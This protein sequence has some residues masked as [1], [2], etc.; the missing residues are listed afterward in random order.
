[1]GSALQRRVEIWKKQL[2]DLGKRNRLVNF[3]EG[4]RNNVKITSPSID[5]M[6]N[7]IVGSERSL[8]FP[9]AMKVEI[10]EDGEESYN[11]VIEGDIET[12]RV[13][14]D[15]QKTLRA[16]RLKAKTSIEEQGI[17]ILYLTFGS[18]K[19][20]ESDN[21]DVFMISP[22]VLVPVSLSIESATSPF[23]LS[24][25]E[26]EIVVNPSLIYKFESDFG[27]NIPEFDSSKDG[28]MDYLKEVDSLTSN[29]GWQITTD[30]HLTI[31]SFLKINMYKDLD[32]HDEKLNSNSVVSAIAGE[33]DAISI[34]SEFND[35][36]HDSNTKP[37]DTYQVVDADSSQQ[38]AVLLSK[39]GTS[40][41]LQGP[42][43]TGKSQTITNIISEALADGKKVLF[44][45]EKMA[46][47]QV[48]YNRLSAVGLSD[49]CLALH[50]HKAKKKDILR[51]LANSTNIDRKRVKEEVLTQLDNLDRK[52]SALNVYQQELH[53]P[54]S[55]LNC[56]IFEVNGRLA[57][58]S[59]VPDI[60]FYIND[61]ET[62]YLTEL[63]ERRYILKELSTTIGKRSEDYSSNVWRNATV[64]YL[65][66]ELRHDI[67]SKFTLL[68]PMLES[69]DRCFKESVKKLG[70]DIKPILN[71]IDKLVEL[72]SLAGTSPTIPTKWV[73]EDDIDLLSQK[74]LDY[75]EKCQKII[76]LKNILS[77]L[78]QDELFNLT[79]TDVQSKITTL[80]SEI[81]KEIAISENSD[82][83]TEVLSKAVDIDNALKQ[84]T[85]LLKET[86]VIAS[87][88]D[89]NLSYLYEIEQV[90]SAIEIL[91]CDIK[92]TSKWFEADANLE[93]KVS[94]YREQH[95]ETARVREDILGNF[96][97]EVLAIDF[98]SILKRFRVEYNSIFRIFNG[99]YKR[100]IKT[101]TEYLSGSLKL[102]YKTALE[103]LTKFKTYS[104]KLSD[105]QVKRD[106]LSELFGSYYQGIDTSWDN[107]IV[108][109][110][111]FRN[112]VNLF[113]GEIPTTLKN[114]LLNGTLPLKELKEYSDRY[115]SSH[116]TQIIDGVKRLEFKSIYNEAKCD[117]VTSAIKSISVSIAELQ[118]QYN[119]INEHRLH[120]DSFTE[121]LSD[122]DK[123]AEYQSLSSS[124][125]SMK[126]EVVAA[127]LD[128]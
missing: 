55:A 45:S 75:K 21:S 95:E 8:Q 110:N 128:Y 88:I 78:Y 1:M 35:F 56:S 103:W 109:I 19:W 101:L 28:I 25:H 73:L 113:N 122:I 121:I 50:S 83:L 70:L 31:L 82:L 114:H 68:L 80:V 32:K 48:V 15:L 120:C 118:Q 20:K 105:I 111:H 44:V 124:I 30:M 4:K 54:C 46:A 92:P 41:V 53:T 12:S 59:I 22:L 16:L 93:S 3:K 47:L 98:Y 117:E 2:L 11:A 64:E 94:M 116:T 52:R 23:V 57:K 33:S 84:F 100:D 65:S 104:D 17:N 10:D 67:D 6:Y 51:N 112:L 91:R 123:L 81:T 62:V 85:P 96:D 34:P 77:S 5:E 24:I 74:A 66:N 79:A 76:D 58:L 38:D 7:L 27:I 72:L 99:N 60:I 87:A 26:D 42:P 37:I 127:Y 43:G 29:K 63:N 115:S 97:K 107:I 13:V 71:N 14:G 9:Y 90:C 102:N 119:S 39:A 18:I 61:V 49:F 106:E 86:E 126:E 89:L 108:D 125:E 69:I 36:D 40:F